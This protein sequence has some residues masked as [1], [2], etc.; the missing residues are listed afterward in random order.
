LYR[1]FFCVRKLFFHA[2][3]HSLKYT[4]SP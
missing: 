1:Y 4:T 2:T 3:T